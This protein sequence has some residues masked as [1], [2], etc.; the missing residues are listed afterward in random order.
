MKIT[1]VSDA[2]SWFN[3]FIPP[4]VAELQAI[5][6][7]VIHIHK[8]KEITDGDIVFYLSC[9]QLVPVE[10]LQRN[11]HN[12][13]IHESD[14]PKGK[15]WSPLTWQILEGQNRIPATMFEAVEAVDSGQIYLQQMMEFTGFE[16]VDDLRKQ[17]A[18]ISLEMCRTFV[19]QYPHILAQAR[20]QEGE[21]TFYPRRRP[22]DSR[23]DIDKSIR[24]QFNLLRVADNERY[25]AYFEIDGHRYK[26]A[27]Y[28]EG[29]SVGAS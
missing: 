12:V 3:P 21:A 18:H 1:I 26:I 20:Q 17:Q 4:F 8:V 28:A 15:G 5:G 22:E 29:T 2:S 27:V 6:H 13:V 23:L 19:N 11:K 14:L 25:P 9:G 24:E 7:E 10:I 16:L